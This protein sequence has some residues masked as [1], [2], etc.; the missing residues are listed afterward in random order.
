LHHFL[1]RISA[2]LAV[3]VTNY[4]TLIE[5]AFRAAGKSYDLIVYP[6]DRKDIANS[7]LWWPYGEAEPLVRQPSEL[8]VDINLDVTTVI[9]KM[10]RTVTRPFQLIALPSRLFQ[11][12]P[13][14]T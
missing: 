7:V 6:A 5:L 14:S 1:A 4:D 12:L 11:A 9:Y 8:A 13:T 10:H 3:V 2:P